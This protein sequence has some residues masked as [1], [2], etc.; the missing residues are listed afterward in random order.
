MDNL[1]PSSLS[2]VVSTLGKREKHLRAAIISL[3]CAKNLV[4][5]ELMVGALLC[6]GI[7]ITNDQARADAVIINTCAFIKS[8]KTESIDAVLEAVE[9]RD[10]QRPKQALIVVGCFPQRYRENLAVLLPEVEAFAGTDEVGNIADLVREAVSLRAMRLREQ[11]RLLTGTQRARESGKHGSDRP[12]R[13]R[14]SHLASGMESA[15][16]MPVV[17]IN[18]RPKYIPSADTPRFRLTPHHYAYLKIAEGCDHRCS[19]CVI[20][21]VRGR[22]RSRTPEDIVAEARALIADGVKELNLIAQDTTAYGRDIVRCR[23]RGSSAGIGSG[24][25]G[26][27]ANDAPS[28]A[29]LLGELQKLPGDFWIRVLYTHPAHWTDTLI[30]SIANCPKVARYVDIPIQHINDLILQRMRRDTRSEHLAGLLKKIRAG[31]PGVAIRTTVIVGFPGE[32]E[33]CFEELLEFVRWARFERL[34]V[35]TYSHEEGTVAGRMADQV[36]EKEKRRRMRLLLREQRRIARDVAASFL[37]RRIRV[38]IEGKTSNE[39]LR[40]ATFSPEHGSSRAH[41]AI[42]TEI[43][44]HDWLVGR[45]EID[46]PDIDG[47]VY[48]RGRWPVGEF[49]NVR[50]MGHTDYD[51]VAEL[52]TARQS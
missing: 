23:A 32:T 15:G 37:G 25:A 21:Q 38:L 4:D 18:R 29:M 45:S 30:E 27:G 39:M 52:E 35:F 46:A 22:Q 50:V 47:R 26:I 12:S 36:P 17:S 31:I 3:G 44:R 13:R 6:A 48:V 5:S 28:L 42:S 1:A 34:G 20:P 11:S 14:R 8:A 2:I 10:S 49:A 24:L 40:H 19:F 9:F 41:E 51:L 43:Q 33:Q 16:L 7:E